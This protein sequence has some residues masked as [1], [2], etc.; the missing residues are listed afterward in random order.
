MYSAPL[1]ILSSIFEL[2]VLSMTCGAVLLDAAGQ[3]SYVHASQIG[4]ERIECIWSIKAN[5][6][7]IIELNVQ[8]LAAT[9][10]TYCN[11]RYLEVISMFSV[12]ILLS[13]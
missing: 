11:Y 12:T 2:S 8:R 6:D 13:F 10:T 3:F 9:D 1:N 7:N 5:W 4:G